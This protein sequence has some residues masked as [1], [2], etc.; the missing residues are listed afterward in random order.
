MLNKLSEAAFMLNTTAMI[1]AGGRGTRMDMF[2][3]HRPKPTLPFGGKYRVIDFTLSNCLNSCIKNIAVLVDY[4]RSSMTEYLNKWSSANNRMEN[5]SV[6]QPENGSYIGTSD[7]VY[8]NLDYLKQAKSERVLILAG[9]HIYKMDYRKMLD[10]HESMKAGVTVGIIRIPIKQ[11][12]RFGTVDIDSEGRITDFVEK[13]SNPQSDLAS[14][15]IYIFDNDILTR[16]LTEDAK[17]K[18]SPHDF[19]YAILPGIVKKERVFGY[20]FKD[21][22]QDIGT[23][24][25]YY[26]ANM[27]LL[28]ADSRF[29]LDQDWPI[30]TSFNSPPI[31][32][33]SENGRIVNSLISPGCVVK[34]YVENSVLSPGVFVGEYAQIINS[35]IMDNGNIGHY[36]I[37]DRCILDE[38]VNVGKFCYLGFG[39]TPQSGV[40]DIT[41]LGKEVSIPPQ[42]TI[43][44]RCKVLPG[45]KMKAADSSLIASGTVLSGAI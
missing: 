41:L 15:G 12:N 4:Q 30:F 22:W 29:R 23:I 35:V 13:S 45:L 21:Y 5:L 36:S 3:H 32:T 43:G 27:E 7:A 8:Q 14:M 42:T 33:K 28:K 10:F 34:G 9:D 6:L 24:E 11:A 16:Y 44:R 39:S 25:A 1:L 31:T 26:E 37:V 2:C 18:N 17:D 38:G 19:G 20:E 40:W